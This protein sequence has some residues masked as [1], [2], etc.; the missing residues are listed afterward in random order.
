LF[1]RILWVVGLAIAC[2]ALWTGV[3]YYVTPVP[4]RPF[5][6]LDELFSPTGLVGQGYGVIGSL[7]MLI[8]VV[9]YSARKRFRILARIGKL[10]DWLH[11]H[12]FLCLVGPF[13]VV[14]HTTFKFGGF[15]AISFWSMVLVVASGVFG[16]Y[17]YAWI[18]KTIS[19]HFLEI[20]EV[21]AQMQGLLQEVRRRTGLTSEQLDEIARPSRRRSSLR[22]AAAPVPVLA[23][24]GPPAGVGELTG[25]AR[26]IDA[27]FED[28]VSGPARSV[29]QGRASAPPTA[30]HGPGKPNPGKG[31]RRRPRRRGILGAIAEA[32]TFRLT[33]GWARRRFHR[34]LAAAGIREPLLSRVVGQLV[35]ERRIEQQVRILQP[36]QRAFRY[37]HAF[38]LP[39]STLMFVVLAL[40]VAVSIAFGYTWIF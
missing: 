38:H 11:F 35:E 18:P 13:L 10:R 34:R 26:S 12:I 6:P 31:K 3:P 33:R 28:P 36:F 30:N 2:V 32:L 1:V 21:R 7:L 24:A 4:E 27:L 23:S 40:H 9:S 22:V 16:R 14:L 39:L 8:G 37:W 20:E 5:S 15:V 29:S 19:G 17:V 25:M